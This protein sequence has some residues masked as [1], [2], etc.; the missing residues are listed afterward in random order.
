MLDS[1][2]IPDRVRKQFAYYFDEKSFLAK[3]KIIAS[4]LRKAI[5]KLF[6]NFKQAAQALTQ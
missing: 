1:F 2:I 6:N 5:G 4:R 3:W